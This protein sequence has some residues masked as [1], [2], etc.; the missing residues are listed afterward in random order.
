MGL[1][2]PTTS[3]ADDSAPQ[4]EA[5]DLLA[6]KDLTQHWTTTGNWIVEPE[7]VVTLKPRAGEGGW[8][9]YGSYLWLKEGDIQDFR[10]EFE[11]RVQKGS[12]SGFYFHVGDQK[13]PVETGVEVQIYDSFGKP[14]KAK[15]TDHDSGG[16]IPGAPPTK[17]SAKPP[18]EWNRMVVTC[19]GTKL[20]VQ[21]NDVVVNEVDLSS[22]KLK[23]RPKSGAIGFQDHG[24]PLSLRK[25]TL[26]KLDAAK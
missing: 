1:A 10:C 18:G 26:R 19:Q 6:G 5:P 8:Q 11:Y 21:L 3:R 7:G 2:Q 17:N 14:P 12:N 23:S 22:G 24:L 15:L 9:R 25:F 16:I 4:G 20:T 13:T